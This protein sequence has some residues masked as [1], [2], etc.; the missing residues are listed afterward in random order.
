VDKS[1]WSFYLYKNGQSI[2]W[3]SLLATTNCQKM[4][5]IDVI[6]DASLMMY[7]LH[8]NV[9]TAYHVLDLYYRFTT[10]RAALLLLIRDVESS[11]KAL[12]HV[13]SLL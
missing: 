11:S 9:I 5:L 1:Q 3:L 7:S 8:L 4:K 12:L 6:S 2:A 10:W 13:L